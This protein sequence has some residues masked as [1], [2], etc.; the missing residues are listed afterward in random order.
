MNIGTRR[1]SRYCDIKLC[2]GIRL[3]NAKRKDSCSRIN[4][5]LA[6]LFEYISEYGSILFF[7]CLVII[8][9]QDKIQPHTKCYLILLNIT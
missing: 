5:K 4:G 1:T 2:I 8:S 7:N 9:Q 3:K 6:H